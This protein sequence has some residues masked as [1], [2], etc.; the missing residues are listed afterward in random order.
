MPG[1][2]CGLASCALLTGISRPQSRIMGIGKKEAGTGAADPG[3]R[4]D[5]S[6]FEFAEEHIM[7]I[8]NIVLFREL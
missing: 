3:M 2:K 4:D 8:Q 1:Q 5:V 7:I 6:K